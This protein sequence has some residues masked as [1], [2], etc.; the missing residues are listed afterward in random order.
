[1]YADCLWRAGKRLVEASLLHI[2]A[3]TIDSFETGGCIYGQQIRSQPHIRSILEM[4][5]V[6]REMPR[7]FVRVVREVDV[8]NLSE[9][10]ARVLR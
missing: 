6:K 3:E 5:L 4:R 8:G 1:M 10:R 2:R 7:P 9:E